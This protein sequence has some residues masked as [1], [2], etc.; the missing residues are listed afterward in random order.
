MD[1]GRENRAYC[2]SKIAELILLQGWPLRIFTESAVAAKDGT[3]TITLDTAPEHMFWGA[4]TK[5]KPGGG[6]ASFEVASVR[7]S[8]WLEHNVVHRQFDD[9]TF[10]NRE[11]AVLMKMGTAF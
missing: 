10:P 5:I 11:P 7:L 9:N 1:P 2:Y 8:R 4:S 6:G 3:T